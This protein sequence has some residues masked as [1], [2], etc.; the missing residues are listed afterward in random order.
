MQPLLILCGSLL[1]GGDLLLQLRTLR[2][3]RQSTRKHYGSD[4]HPA[5]AEA[6][7]EIGARLHFSLASYSSVHKFS[8][9]DVCP[10]NPQL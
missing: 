4:H 6:Q 5:F 2:D 9:V 3:Q 10:T 1:Y 7:K 8:W